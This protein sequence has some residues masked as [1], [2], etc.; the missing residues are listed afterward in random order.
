MDG[1]AIPRVIGMSLCA[2]ALMAA[3]PARAQQ[4]QNRAWCENRDGRRDAWSSRSP[5]AP[6]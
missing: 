4:D 1:E 2:A 3:V 5:A 6:R